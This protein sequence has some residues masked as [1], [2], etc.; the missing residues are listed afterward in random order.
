MAQPG[1]YRKINFLALDN[2]VKHQLSFLEPLLAKI[3]EKSFLQ[4]ITTKTEAIAQLDHEI[5][6][7]A[8]YVINPALTN[9]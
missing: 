7:Q 3:G 4:Y 8:V 1:D 5:P 9:K 2:K 6:A